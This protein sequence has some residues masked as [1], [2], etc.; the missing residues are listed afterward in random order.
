M[1][2]RIRSQDRLPARFAGVWCSLTVARAN[3]DTSLG[4]KITAAAGTQATSGKVG[5]SVFIKG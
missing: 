5:I 1:L 4:V 3:T 2:A